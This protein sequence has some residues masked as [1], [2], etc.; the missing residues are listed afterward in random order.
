VD[1]KREIANYAKGFGIIENIN[2]NHCSKFEIAVDKYSIKQ[3]NK[4]QP[5]LTFQNTSPTPQHPSTKTID[6]NPVKLIEFKWHGIYK[7]PTLQNKNE[8]SNQVLHHKAGSK[9]IHTWISLLLM[10][11]FAKMDKMIDIKMIAIND[12][13]REILSVELIKVYN[14]LLA[15]KTR[16]I[17]AKV[18]TELNALRSLMKTF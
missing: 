4:I 17:M 13:K 9:N 15:T 6:S 16:E 11:D 5:F 10:E 12:G 18:L 7:I 1:L 3:F 14:M 8:I 2:V